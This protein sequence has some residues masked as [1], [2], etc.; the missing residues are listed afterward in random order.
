MDA[1]AETVAKRRIRFVYPADQNAMW[2]P[3]KPEVAIASNA[4]SLLLPYL[5]PWVA[6]S[7]RDAGPDLDGAL[8]DE[9]SAYVFQEVQHH[10]QHQRLNEIVAKRYRGI[11]RLE[12]VIAF[13]FA[14]LRRRTSARFGLAFAAGFETLAYSGA[15]WTETRVDKLFGRADAVPAT[16][17][18]W[19][20]AEEIEHKSVAWDV[21][22]ST[23]GGRVRYAMGALL[24]L[25]LLVSFSFAGAVLI[26]IGERR[27][28]HPVAW[29]R[30][31]VWSLGV[32]FE[33]L[34]TFAMSLLG[35]HHPSQLA[36]PAWFGAWLATYDADT[37][38]LPLWNEL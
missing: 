21:Y 5:E 35:R 18:L 25:W 23:G 28:F 37:H 30:L 8:A 17:F 7:V 15:R 32:L 13:V 27:I 9:A 22:K 10:K 6:A 29:W 31:I 26:L 19:H 1:P 38:T 20:L 2:S 33:M 3:E 16:L 12:R 24:S 34:P 11:G 4:V 14:F 36:D